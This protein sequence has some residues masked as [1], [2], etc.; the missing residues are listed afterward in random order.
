MTNDE[1][2]LHD[3]NTQV[4]WKLAIEG[5]VSQWFAENANPMYKQMGLDG[6]PGIDTNVGWLSPIKV[7]MDSYVYKTYDK[8][9]GTAAPSGYTTVVM[10]THVKDDL[11]LEHRV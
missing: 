4:K 9:K 10:L 11:Y 7:H 5:I 6:H 8:D 2:K 1:R 3:N